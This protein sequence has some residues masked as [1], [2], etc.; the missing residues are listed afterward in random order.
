MGRASKVVELKRRSPRQARSRDTIETIFEATARIIER[1]GRAALNTNHI[2]ERAG[3]SVGTLYQYFPNKEAILVAMARRELENDRAAVI[4]AISAALD[5]PAAEIARPAIRTLIELHRHRQKV[6]AV[7]MQTHAAHGL[8]D[9]HVQPL[10]EVTELLS[11]RSDRIARQYSGP[12]SAAMLFIV[13]RAVLG[14]IR[15][16]AFERS[17]LLGTAEFE[18]EL[19]RLVDGYLA[20]FAG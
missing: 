4:R 20:A 11:A 14:V 19:V 2:A 6:R 12:L 1:G 7:V 17:P 13:T 8:G 3:I 15:A 16:A 9:E 10:R 5:D 18:D